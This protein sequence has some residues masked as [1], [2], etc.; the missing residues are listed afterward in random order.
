[1]TRAH[2]PR[3]RIAPVPRRSPRLRHEAVRYWVSVAVSVVVVGFGTLVVVS[4][5]ATVPAGATAVAIVYFSAWGTFALTYAVLTWAV[6]R[7]AD[8]TTLSSWLH[9]SGGQERRRRLSQLVLGSGGTSAAISLVV[10]ALGAVVVVAVLPVLRQDPVVV[11]LAVMVVVA[12]WLLLVVV[13]AVRYASDGRRQASLRFVETDDNALVFSDFCYLAVQVVATFSTSDVV[14]TSA[15]MR[16]EITTHSV[17]A[18]AF[19][20]VV[21]ALLVSLLITAAG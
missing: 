19:N 21:V 14:V 12:S 2:S 1:M 18:F 8:A 16:R 7:R 10:I 6:L 3:G 4:A 11:V 20:T 9:E 15:A 13:L 5:G 17:V